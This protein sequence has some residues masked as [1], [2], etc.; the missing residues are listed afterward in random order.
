MNIPEA[1]GGGG[2]ESVRGDEDSAVDSVSTGVER[3]ETTDSNEWVCLLQLQTT[4]I[5]VFYFS[6][7]VHPI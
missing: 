4:S 3:N 5:T 1:G 2:E 7:S 6:I